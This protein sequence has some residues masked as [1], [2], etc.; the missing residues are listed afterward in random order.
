RRGNKQQPLQLERLDPN[1]G[2]PWSVPHVWPYT[3]RHWRDIPLRGPGRACRH[4][5]MLELIERHIGGRSGHSVV[6]W[7]TNHTSAG[8]GVGHVDGVVPAVKLVL[9][10]GRYIHT[11]NLQGRRHGAL[12]H[13]WRDGGRMDERIDIPNEGGT[14]G[15]RRAAPGPL[16]GMGLHV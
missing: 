6:A 16:G 2:R 10:L 15:R 8:F 7:A 5:G 13:R 12:G 14:N 4:L 11:P 3:V 1:A 9:D